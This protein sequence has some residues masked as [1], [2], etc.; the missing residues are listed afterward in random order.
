MFWIEGTTWKT[1][2]RD[3]ERIAEQV[4]IPD[5]DRSSDSSTKITAVSRWLSTVPKDPWLVI[6][7]GINDEAALSGPLG[8]SGRGGSLIHLLPQPRR[9]RVLVTT[10][11]AAVWRRSSQC[12][13]PVCRRAHR[14]LRSRERGAC[15]T[16]TRGRGKAKSARARAIHV[17]RAPV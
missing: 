6:I 9:G 15:P 4:Q 16:P 13:S 7:D 12:S 1:V 17:R 2:M 3:F 14:H 8:G 5:L 10:Q 11:N